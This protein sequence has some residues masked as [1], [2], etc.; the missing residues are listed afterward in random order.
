[1]G[2][3]TPIT[4]L[5]SSDNTG[6]LLEIKVARKDDFESIPEPVDGIVYGDIEFKEGRSWCQWDGTSESAGIDSKERNGREGASAGNVL[7]VFFPK[8]RA[9]LRT[10]FQRASEDELIILFRDANGKLKLFGLLYAPVQFRFSHSTGSSIADRNGYVGEFYFDGPD[11]IYE[12]DGSVSAPIAGPPPS[13]VKFN[14][15][16]IASLQPGEIFN[17]VSDFGFTDFY[18]SS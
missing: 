2:Y 14:G 10:M 6:G 1:M 18:I 15:Q 9:Y 12:Y 4:R 8:D 7:K 5:S 3:L 11:N 16:S 13:I 17:I